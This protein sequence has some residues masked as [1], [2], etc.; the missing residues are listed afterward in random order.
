MDNSWKKLEG[1]HLCEDAKLKR[2]EEE[3]KYVAYDIV[4]IPLKRKSEHL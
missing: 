2:V 1:E 4:F 3:L